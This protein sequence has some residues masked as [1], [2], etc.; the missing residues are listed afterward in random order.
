MTTVCVDLG[1]NEDSVTVGQILQS[2][3]QKH[4]VNNLEKIA[5]ELCIRPYYLAAL[6]Q[7]DFTSFPSACYAS[8]FLRNYASYLGLNATEVVSKY[9][10]AYTGAVDE[11]ELDFPDVAVPGDFSFQT[12]ASYAG[13][14]LLL[15][16]GVWFSANQV[17]FDNAQSIASTIQEEA[18]TMHK[19]VTETV[20]A[21]VIPQKTVAVVSEKSMTFSLIDRAEAAVPDI[22]SASAVGV[23]LKAREDAWV[24]I[25]GPDGEVFIDRILHK[26][27]EFHAPSAKGLVLMTSNAAALA[28]NMGDTSMEALGKQGQIVESLSLEQDN[29][30]QL[31]TSL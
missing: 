14:S 25:V 3:R 31:A 28:L 21:V 11:V 6:E 2:A 22:F 13:V 7:D 16:C 30:V 23:S 8:G 15:V 4:G 18:V 27:E 29:L 20:R 12:V 19:S 17:S 24:R 10:K 26:G 9:K 1:V 5:G